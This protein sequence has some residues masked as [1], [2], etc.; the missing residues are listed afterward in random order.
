V[1]FTWSAVS[2]A[3]DYALWLGSTGV[4]SNNL[5]SSGGTTATSF[6]K[7]GLPTNGE[8]IYVRLWTMLSGSTLHADYMY[9]AASQAV[10]TSPTPDSAFTG[11][12]VTFKWTAAAGATSYALWLGS[13]GVGSNNLGSS[14]GTTATSYTKN[15][16]PTNGETI[17]VRLWTT[18]G[19]SSVHADYTYT[20][21]SQ[22]MLTSPTP[23]STF[24][25][26]S[27][28]FTWTAVSGATGYD[29]WLGS[30]GV[31]S[32]N[33]G[34]SGATTA[35]SYTKNGLPTNGETIYVRLFTIFNGVDVH[36][37][38]TYTAYTAGP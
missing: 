8:T 7:T 14:G 25:G 17:Y 22:S 3:T 37:D 21:A 27:E 11:S 13:T 4:G 36:T 31:G 12:S 29:I 32:N 18:L 2:G 20:A 38:Y 23:G 6:T 1:T 24:T 19:G 35:L 16:L 30:T 9:T 10:L 15:G 33:L 5:G 28:T 26:S 34:G